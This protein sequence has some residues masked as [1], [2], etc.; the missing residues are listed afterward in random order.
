MKVQKEELIALFVALRFEAAGEWDLAK[1]EDMVG[2]MAL[3]VKEEEV[4]EPHRELFHKIA[5]SADQLEIVGYERKTKID[6]AVDKAAANNKE[7]ENHIVTKSKNKTPEKNGS[8]PKPAKAAAKSAKPAKAKKAPKEKKP[9]VP[10]DEFG[11]RE[12]SIRAKVNA[13]FTKE[14]Q[15]FEDIVQAS[16]IKERQVRS[17]LRRACRAGIIEVR[18]IVEYRLKPKK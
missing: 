16:G 2:K 18:K 5:N 14:W 3:K 9:E 4:P 6:R 8:K 15:P 17:R 13:T 7:K 1:M 10:R 12:G 11:S